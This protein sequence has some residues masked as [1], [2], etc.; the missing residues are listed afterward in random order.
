MNKAIK[1]IWLL[2]LLLWSSLNHA[3]M[4]SQSEFIQELVA[5][6]DFNPT[7]LAQWLAKAKVRPS[8]LKAISRPGEAKP[9]YQYRPIFV[10]PPRIRAGVQFWQ[11]HAKT[12]AQANA[13][14]GVP[15]EIIVAI[16]GVE[17]FYGQEMGNFRVIDALTTLAFHY[18]PRAPF[19]REELT[20]FFLLCRE[21]GLNPLTPKGSYAGAMGL[22]QFMPSSFRK[23]AV[24]LDHN[25]KRNIWNNVTDVIGSIANYLKQHGWKANQPVITA[26]QVHPE[27]VNRPLALELR[28][29]E[30]LEQAGLLFYGERPKNAQGMLIDLETEQGT[31]YWLGFQNFYV[32]TRYNRSKHY[33]MA[34]YQLAQE[35]ATHYAKSP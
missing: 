5:R 22:G 26:T 35:I 10:N 31:A 29:L 24:D 28:P 15:A 12:L 32:I 34:V 1:I 6:H 19:F 30:Q 33:A 23:Y 9:W 4:L 14:Y 8:I 27:A 16:I 11:K 21:E 3:Q 13:I 2:G 7:H 25:G 20:N 18:P 17:T